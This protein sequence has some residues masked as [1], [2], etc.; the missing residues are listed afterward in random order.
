MIAEGGS[1]M[2]NSIFVVTL[3]LTITLATAV[4]A[5]AKGG[6]V[7]TVKYKSGDEDVSAF[8]TLPDSNR[9]GKGPFP[10][11]VVIH[12]WW[13]LNDWIRINARRFAGKGYVALAIDLYRGKVADTPDLAHELMRGVPEDRAERDLKAAVTYLRSRKGVDPK[14]IGAI[15]WCMGGG[16]SLTLALKQSDLTAAVIC[17]GR[18]A[19]DRM[20]L[21]NVGAAV[22]GIFG[23]QDGGIPVKDVRQLEQTLRELG[24]KVEIHVYENAGHAFMNPNN[25]R[26]YREADAKDA[27]TKVD[28]F[29]QRMLGK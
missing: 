9:Y 12:E 6:P 13:G 27:W 24:K 11:I 1:S 4:Q 29:F 19:T 17:Y 14:R 18:L 16:Y 23:G 22:L 8:L 28:T 15:G 5:S 2:I 26:G 7:S 10:A 20:A 25:K 3:T 21:G